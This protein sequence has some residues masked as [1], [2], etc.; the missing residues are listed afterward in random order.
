MENDKYDHASHDHVFLSDPLDFP[1]AAG[2][3]SVRKSSWSL[4][5]YLVLQSDATMQI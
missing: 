3:R 2:L 4:V 1:L 5:T